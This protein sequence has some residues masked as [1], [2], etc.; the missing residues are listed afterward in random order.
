MECH[1]NNKYSWN[2]YRQ[3]W[4]YTYYYTFEVGKQ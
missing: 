3:E 2:Y 1:R 4:R